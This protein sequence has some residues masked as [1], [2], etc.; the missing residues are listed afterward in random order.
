MKIE[1]CRHIKTCDNG[2][3]NSCEGCNIYNMFY[4]EN[5]LI[6]W[7]IKQKVSVVQTII[8]LHKEIG[9]KLSVIDEETK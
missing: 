3:N 8:H 6:D 1:I 4:N 9:M 2:K 7:C 5:A